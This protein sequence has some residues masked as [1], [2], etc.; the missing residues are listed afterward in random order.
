VIEFLCTAGVS[1]YEPGSLQARPE[2]SAVR[3]DRAMLLGWMTGTTR[4]GKPYANR[5]AFAVRF[6]A[7]RV[8]EGLE[9]LDSKELLDHL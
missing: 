9:L 1:V 2:V 4:S 6:R 5:Y 7:A 8:I 3:G